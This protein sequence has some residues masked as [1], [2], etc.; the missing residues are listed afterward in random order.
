MSTTHNERPAQ[1]AKQHGKR[2]GAGFLRPG[3]SGRNAGHE[4]PR[5]PFAAMFVLF[6]LWWLL[7]PGEAA[8]IV[9]AAVMLVLLVRRGR[10]EVPRGYG[11]WLL[12]LLWLALSV[13]GIDTGGRLLGF[14]YRACLYLTVT[15]VFLYVYNARTAFTPRYVAG[16]LT[17]FWG[18]VV[19]GGY[20]GVF[21]PLF[22]FHTPLGLVLSPQLSANDLVQEMVV[23]RVT[24]FNPDS[25][26]QLEPRPS[27]PFLYTNGWGNAYSVLLPI[28]VA[29]L[30]LV[31]RERR[32]W[33]ILLAIPLSFVP[34]FL[35]LNRGMFL[36]LGLALVYVAGRAI[37]RG[38]LKVLLALVAFLALV[39]VAFAVL[40][41]ADRISERVSV[42]STTADRASLYQETFERTLE[43]PLFGYGA[44]RPSE[45]VGAPSA[46]TQG[47]FWM[48]LFSFGFPGALLFMGWLI[49]AYL[50]SRREGDPLSVAFSVVLLVTVVEC[51]FYGILTTGLMV[52]MIAAAL[53]LPPQPLRFSRAR[54]Y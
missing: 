51:L 26:L 16:V 12:F 29:Y 35:T 23:R 42:S 40:P 30:F 43:S 4:L 18:I 24:Q 15:I 34:A 17:V 46:G 25:Y 33:F 27:A 37:A 21:F 13:I 47:Q 10:I 44:P 1:P 3:T 39:G 52:A 32:F 8:W 53:A 41:I 9:L 7:G 5:W 6:P 14:I 38:S 19:V 48:V 45:T 36:G 50:Q 49:W 31:R 11:I 54:L 22:S 28:V 20:L 2:T